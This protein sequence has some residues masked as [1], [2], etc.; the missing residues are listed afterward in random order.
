[1]RKPS[2]EMSPN[3]AGN[4]SPGPRASRRRRRGSPLSIRRGLFDSVLVRRCP[5]PVRQAKINERSG[6]VDENKGPLT[7]AAG[8]AEDPAIVEQPVCGTY[9]EVIARARER[10]AVATTGGTPVPRSK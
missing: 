1:M 2:R 4:P 9:V 6:N 8:Q 5:A 3:E 10:A 7:S